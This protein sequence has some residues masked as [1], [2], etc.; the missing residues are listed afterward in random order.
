MIVHRPILPIPNK[1]ETRGTCG[2]DDAEDTLKGKF[3]GWKNAV[4]RE[5]DSSVALSDT[6]T[7]QFPPKA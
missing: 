7:T 3:L 4:E 1:G 6:Q 5:L 2:G